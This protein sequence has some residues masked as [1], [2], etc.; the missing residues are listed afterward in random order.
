MCNLH[1][2]ACL[3]D[4]PLLPGEEELMVRLSNGTTTVELTDGRLEVWHNNLWGTVCSDGFDLRD[5]IV[6]CRQLNLYARNVYL[7]GFNFDIDYEIPVLLTEVGCTGSETNIGYCSHP[8]IGAADL[9]DCHHFSDVAVECS[10]GTYI[11]VTTISLLY[12][13]ILYYTILYYTILHYTI[14][15]FTL[16][17]YTVLGLLQ[18]FTAFA[19]ENVLGNFSIRL[20]DGAGNYEGRVE[21]YFE[22]EW[23]T[24]C[25]DGFG[26]T[27]GDVVCRSLGYPRAAQV[28]GLAR[29]GQGT[30]SILMDNVACDGSED[31][32]WQ[33]AFNGWGI[34][35]CVHFEDASVSC[36][37]PD[38]PSPGG[39]QFEVRLV[40]G[41]FPYEGRVE[42][43]YGNAWGSVC[44]E[45]WT[46]AD[47]DVVCNQLGYDGAVEVYSGSQY[48]G[49]SGEVWLSE[50]TC[51]GDESRLV[52][53]MFPGWGEVSDECNS[54]T[55]DAGVTCRG[56]QF[57]W[58]TVHKYVCKIHRFGRLKVCSYIFYIDCFTLFCEYIILF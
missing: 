42:I 33:C 29:F 57:K 19:A 6:V 28:Y 13:T 15:Y 26:L 58:Y 39:G 46:K 48:G 34:E 1:A 40:G 55:R 25:D 23:G 22:G 2:L 54:H 50:T 32:I 10:D 5:A 4:E 51:Q 20:V 7:A 9:E 56:K 12:Y 30:G 27:D 16:L 36:Y 41:L 24:V 18:F 17:Y 11:H 53:C 43:Y 44:D 47:G 14:L 49:G 35:N 38:A 31:A 8:G 37:D 3:A 21:V 45:G 52:D